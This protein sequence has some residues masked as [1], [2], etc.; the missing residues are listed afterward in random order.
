MNGTTRHT[1][2]F[3]GL[4]RRHLVNKVT[5]DVEKTGSVGI[6]INDVI[7]PDFII[8]GAGCAHGF[9]HRILKKGNGL[10]K[11]ADSLEGLSG[12]RKSAV[13]RP[14]QAREETCRQTLMILQ[15]ENI[16][17]ETSEFRS[18]GHF[19]SRLL[20]ALQYQ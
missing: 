9:I 12:E 7:I 3:K 17:R 13:E 2:T 6:T 5:V 10:R 18:H 11:K 14:G 1:Q 19:I 4:R 15:H 20:P 8:K 16:L